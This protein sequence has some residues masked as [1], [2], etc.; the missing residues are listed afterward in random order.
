MVKNLVV[1]GGGIYRTPVS[2]LARQDLCHMQNL[3]HQGAMR[4]FFL[5]SADNQFDRQS[6]QRKVTRTSN[7]MESEEESR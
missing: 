2:S 6:E 4:S 3:L 5:F 1:S 7:N